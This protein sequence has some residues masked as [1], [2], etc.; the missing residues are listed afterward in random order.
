[1]YTNSRKT[2]FTFMFK[3]NTLPWNYIHV[4]IIIENVFMWTLSWPLLGILL[5][6]IILSNENVRT[7]WWASFHWNV[8]PKRRKHSM[9]YI[10]IYIFQ[11][12]AS[13]WRSFQAQFLHM[14]NAWPNPYFNIKYTEFTI[15]RNVMKVDKAFAEIQVNSSLICVVCLFRHRC[16]MIFIIYL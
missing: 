1:M 15:C 8:S 12:N 5:W 6:K 14:M 9:S 4:S 13:I 10:Y 16:N 2:R 3:C 7:K 11:G